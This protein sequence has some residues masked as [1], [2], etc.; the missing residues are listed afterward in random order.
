MGAYNKDMGSEVDCLGGY[1]PAAV[2]FAKTPGVLKREG[3]PRRIGILS[4]LQRAL[5]KRRRLEIPSEETDMI[6]GEVEE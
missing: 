4:V 2:R 3:S 5:G 6:K 1:R